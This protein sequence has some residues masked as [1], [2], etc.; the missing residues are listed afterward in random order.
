MGLLL[1]CVSSKAMP[2]FVMRFGIVL[3]LLLVTAL[4]ARVNWFKRQPKAQQYELS[5]FYCGFGG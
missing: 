1:K 3:A 2:I 4:S 5:M